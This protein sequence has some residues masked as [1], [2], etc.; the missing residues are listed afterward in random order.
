[1]AAEDNAA[2][3]RGWAQAAYNQHDLEAA[4]Q[5]LAPDWVG[6]WA[7]LGE[8]HGWRASSG[9]LAPTFT[10]S[11]TCRSRSRT[12]SLTATGWSAE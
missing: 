2:I 9:W 3:V 1:M 10:P 4:A 11:R 6:H 8:E 5:F 12:H 7:G